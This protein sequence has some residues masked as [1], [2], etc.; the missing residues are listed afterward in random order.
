MPPKAKRAKIIHDPEVIKAAIEAI[1]SKKYTQRKAAKVYGIPQTTLSD[2]MKGKTPIHVTPNTLLTKEEEEKL[3]AWIVELARCGF[4]KTIE[5]VKETAAQILKLRDAASRSKESLPT[6]AWVYG[7]FNRHPQLSIRRPISLGKERATVTPEALKR[8]FTALHEHLQSV[9]PSLIED[10]SRI[11]N[12]DETGFSFDVKNRRVVACKGSKHVY[13][14][15][16][17]TK[18]Q[19][20]ALATVSAAGHYLPPLLIYPYKRIP[21]KNLIQDFPE[22]HIQV[23]DNGWITAAIFLSWIQDV[24]IPSTAHIKKPLLLLVDGHT[25]HTSLVETSELCEANGIILFCLHP[26]ASHIIQP[27]DQAFFGSIKSAWSNAVRKHVFETGDGVG[28]DSFAKVLKP[29]WTQAATLNNAVKS[30]KAAGIFPFNPSRAVQSDKLAPAASF[31]AEVQPEPGLPSA[32]AAPQPASDQPSASSAPQPEPGPSSA[33]SAPQPEPGPSSASSAPQPEPGPSSASSAP[34][35]EPGPSS[36]SSAPQPEPGPSTAPPVS[37]PEPGPSSAPP[38]SQPEPGLPSALSVSQPASDQPSTPSAPRPLPGLPDFP[39]LS[40]YMSALSEPADLPVPHLPDLP[41]SPAPL[42]DEDSPTDPAASKTN[43]KFNSKQFGA[44][45]DFCFFLYDDVSRNQFVRYFSMLA[46][47]TADLT[48]RNFEKFKK[49]SLSLITECQQTTPEKKTAPLTV[50]DLLQSPKYA[51]KGKT[52]KRKAAPT[53][54]LVLSGA[55]YRAA[56]D[57]KYREKEKVEQEKLAR[58]VVREENKRKKEQELEQKR[59]K[60]QEEKEARMQKKKEEEI[61]KQQ[62]KEMLNLKKRKPQQSDTDS[63]ADDRQTRKEMEAMLADSEDEYF[64]GLEG[65][66]A[67]TGCHKLGGGLWA[68]CDSCALWWHTQ[69]TQ[70]LRDLNEEQLVNIN[71]VCSQCLHNS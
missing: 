17:N 20:T 52:K 45:K 29:V 31:R 41:S 56:I 49:L 11:Y 60:R 22:A 25:S 55:D 4:G 13:A 12:S 64:E 40:F 27:L 54:P 46:S 30:F 57:K 5:E 36:A 42:P 6:K 14:V 2:K 68:Q 16:A 34:Q 35:P 48:D 38:V 58:K 15:T 70:D 23:S 21:Q 67:C 26:H 62:R 44:L 10:P 18:H 3:A 33:S 47:D 59:R 53:L 19:V 9:E 28:L 61:A 37:Q 39:D 51:K 50:D 66:D 71:F 69:C 43:P 32:S 1:K 8:W 63:E 24:F 65:G 7:F